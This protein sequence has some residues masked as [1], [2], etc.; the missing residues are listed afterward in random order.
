LRAASKAESS[1]LVLAVIV[2]I[3][4]GRGWPSGGW[5]LCYRVFDIFFL[6]SLL[7]LIDVP[8]HLFAPFAVFLVVA[9]TASQLIETKRRRRG[10]LRSLQRAFPGN[11]VCNVASGCFIAR[12]IQPLS[13]VSEAGCINGS[14]QAIRCTNAQCGRA[15]RN[16]PRRQGCPVRYAATAC[17]VV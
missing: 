12:I 10:A 9:F 7:S 2:S 13:A 17:S 16:F 15:E 11:P 3:S 4:W 5:A 1:V 14:R 6:P 8:P